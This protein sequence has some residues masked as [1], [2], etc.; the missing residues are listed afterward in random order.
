M[1]N[2]VT[3]LRA[4][5]RVAE[6][7][8]DSQA[9]A[10]LDLHGSPREANYRFIATTPLTHRRLLDRPPRGSVGA[11][12]GSE[13]ACATTALPRLAPGGRL[14]PYTGVAIVQG[15]RGLMRSV[16]D[17]R[18]DRPRSA[19]NDGPRTLPCGGPGNDAH[20]VNLL[21]PSISMVLAGTARLPA[22]D[23]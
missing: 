14:L 8:G 17:L 2:S 13:R 7:A 21:S 10:L 1:L 6:P 20:M 19:A 3:A 12:A 16:V 22:G 5:A 9:E 15:V 23:R 18:A 4:S 11:G